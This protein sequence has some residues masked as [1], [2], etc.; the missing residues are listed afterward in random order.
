MPYPTQEG[1]KDVDAFI[2]DVLLGRRLMIFP[3]GASAFLV[4]NVSLMVGGGLLVGFAAV[5]LAHESWAI[6]VP[7]RA[8]LAVAGGGGLTVAMSAASF[9][10][11]RGYPHGH[12]L[13]RY[14]GVLVALLGGILPL[15][16][17]AGASNL[18]AWQSALPLPFLFLANVALR[19]RRYH[20]YASFMRR[21]RCRRNELKRLRAEALNQLDEQ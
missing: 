15:L 12:Q 8:L 6:G 2:D 13:F 10:V 9:L 5:G 20:V 11:I 19:S 7:L 18:P 17:I 16:S 3:P 14:F 4:C 1:P 21:M